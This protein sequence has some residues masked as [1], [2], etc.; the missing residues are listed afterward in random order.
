MVPVWIGRLVGVGIPK[1]LACCKCPDSLVSKLKMRVPEQH[2][3]DSAWRAPASPIH[4]WTSKLAGSLV[5]VCAVGPWYPL[6]YFGAAFQV[7]TMLLC[8]LWSLLKLHSKPDP[9][10]FEVAHISATIYQACVVVC[11]VSTL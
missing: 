2:A 8:E 1:L 7:T 6:V 4:I 10:G 3:L 5:A 9:R 11:I